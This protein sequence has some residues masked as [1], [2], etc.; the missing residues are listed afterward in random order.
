MNPGYNPGQ[1]D[2]FITILSKKSTCLLRLDSGSIGKETKR[3]H[4]I[5]PLSP[6][7]SKCQKFHI[8]IYPTNRVPFYVVALGDA[9][10]HSSFMKEQFSMLS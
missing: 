3:L 4:P 7:T 6:A 10:S 1:S 8:E 9:I 2:L 5:S